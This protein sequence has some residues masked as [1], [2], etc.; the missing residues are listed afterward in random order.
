MALRSETDKAGATVLEPDA[1]SYDAAGCAVMAMEATL[2]TKELVV[3]PWSDAPATLVKKVMVNPVPASLIMLTV[4]ETSALP[5]L[6]VPDPPAAL[7]M[8]EPIQ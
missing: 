5:P 3:R 8:L 1:Y 7:V 2:I 4:S 6:N